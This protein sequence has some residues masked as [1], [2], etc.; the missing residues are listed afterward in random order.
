V[1]GASYWTVG[2]AR[3]PGEIRDDKEALAT[4]ERFAEN[5]AWLAGKT[6]GQAGQGQP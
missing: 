6:R 3:K 4:V 1:P 5:L 2:L